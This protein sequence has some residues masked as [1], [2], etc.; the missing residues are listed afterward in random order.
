M[1][2]VGKAL[3][4]RLHL[5]FIAINEL[6]QMFEA[7]E[8]AGRVAIEINHHIVVVTGLFATAYIDRRA[9]VSYRA[10][11]EKT[12][13]NMLSEVRLKAFN[14]RGIAT[15]DEYAVLFFTGLIGQ[16]AN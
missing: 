11:G 5:G 4:F 1:F 13:G 16:L 8:P 9:V 10:V 12:T 2:V 14:Q 15:V 3:T 7:A 6:G